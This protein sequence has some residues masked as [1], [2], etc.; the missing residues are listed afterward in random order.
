MNEVAQEEATI[1]AW[2]E[3]GVSD[4]GRRISS[5]TSSAQQPAESGG[6]DAEPLSRARARATWRS[7]LKVLEVALGRRVP[8]RGDGFC[9]LY[10]FMAGL[11]AME[12]PAVP[13]RGDYALAREFLRELKVYV[14]AK[15]GELEFLSTPDRKTFLK[16]ADPPTALNVANYGRATLHVPVIACYT[17]ITVFVLD[18][19]D[20]DD[21]PRSGKNELVAT[22]T[23][24]I[25]HLTIV[26]GGTGKLK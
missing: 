9:W 26:E 19:L 4:T 6:G 18:P 17:G 21:P 2:K 20:P 5:S 14:T 10:A 13:T 12:N 8:C 22:V 3:R 11:N 1:K 16:M 23:T 25:G 24:C 15:A 7:T